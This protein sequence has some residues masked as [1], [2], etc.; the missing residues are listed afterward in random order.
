MIGQLNSI[1][2]KLDWWLII[3]YLLLAI[4]GWLNIYSAIYNEEHPSIFDFSQRYGMQFVWIVSSIILGAIIIFF[5]NPKVYSVLSP[6]IYLFAVLLLFAV[7]FIGKEVNGSK[8]WFVIGPVGFQPAEISKISTALFLS[9]VMSRYGFKLGRLKDAAKVA[10]ILL[11]PMAFIILEKE[12]GSAL[13]YTGF[14]F[15]LYREGLNGWLLAFGLL[16]VFLF[17]VSL[18]FSSYIAIIWLFA[19]LALL[20]GAISRNMPIHILIVALLT[21]FLAYLPRILQ[22]DFLSFI[23]N[24]KLEYWALV[25]IIP[26]IGF[27]LVKAAQKRM[28]HVKFIATCFV[29]SVMF[30][31]SVGFIFNNILQPHQR[32]RIENLL[33]IEEDLHGAGYNVHQSKI[34]IGSGGFFGKGFLDGTQTKFNFVPEQ[35]TDFIFCTI[36]EEHGFIGSVFVIL[37]YIFLIIRLIILSERQ[38]DSFNRIYGYCVACCFFM[39]FFINIGM[40]MGLMPVIGI[41]L[42]LLSYGGSSLWAFT[43]LLAILDRKSVV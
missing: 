16:A 39:H 2:R 34:A 3:C 33:G 30:I 6:L 25:F 8:S 15:M 14:V 40:T 42:P 43:I 4:I 32:A 7:I 13:V 17:V 19:I 9:Y 36:G 18:A 27:A 38:K 37:L 28:H 10:A 29:L 21:I 23:P 11:V 31:F 41:P 26:I 1:Y 35:S 20:N 12:T 24:M 5:I 22:L